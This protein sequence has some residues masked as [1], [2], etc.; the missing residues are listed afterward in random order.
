MG[1][2]DIPESRHEKL[3]KDA[4]WLYN[5]QT[6]NNGI[7]LAMMNNGFLADIH[8]NMNQNIQRLLESINEEI[9]K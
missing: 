6:F 1:I 7:R 5:D 2:E 3:I 8:R 4:Q 9:K